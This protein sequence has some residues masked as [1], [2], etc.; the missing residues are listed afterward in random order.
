MKKFHFRADGFTEDDLRRWKKST[1]KSVTTNI[2]VWSL[3][4][5]LI[6]TVRLEKPVE[7][8][9]ISGIV[10]GFFTTDGG[11]F[12]LSVSP[13]DPDGKL[14]IKGLTLNDFFFT[15][16]KV[17]DS[18]NPKNVLGEGK[19]IPTSFKINLAARLTGILVF[20]SSG[21]MS[22]NDPK[23]LRKF[24]GNQ[25]V[26]RLGSN[27]Q[28]AI[29]NFAG[30]QISVL[31]EFTSKKSLLNKAINKISAD[32]GTPLYAALVKA[33]GLLN[34]LG[35]KN[36]AILVL[37]DGQNDTD[38]PDIFADVVNQANDVNIPIFPIGLGSGID[39]SQ[40]QE[41]ALRTGGTFALAQNAEELSALFD[42]LAIS[43][44]EGRIIVNAKGTFAHPLTKF[45]SYYVSGDLITKSGG[46]SITTPFQ[47]IVEIQKKTISN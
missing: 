10:P 35:A 36:P 38:K 14:I 33:I 46:N 34:T 41:L 45:G 11:N 18:A 40:L 44:T 13:L 42:K 26:S 1:Q 2:L 21:S 3:V 25:F 20:D 28:V 31:Q 12:M 30:D 17:A 16:I 27:D 8:A 37:T 29:I 19:V 24:A 43:V 39:F 22:T 9:P 6:Y 7:S 5:V 15:P 4:V 47:F 32:G 23:D